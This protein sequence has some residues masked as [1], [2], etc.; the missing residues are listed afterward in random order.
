MFS[1]NLKI[2]IRKRRRAKRIL[3][4]FSILVSCPGYGAFTPSSQTPTWLP[5]ASTCTFWPGSF[6][7]FCSPWKVDLSRLVGQLS[8]IRRWDFVHE[9]PS[10]LDF[11]TGHLRDM[12]LTLASRVY[13]AILNSNSFQ[14]WSEPSSAP[15][16]P[17]VPCILYILLY[18]SGVSIP[19][20]TTCTRNLVSTSA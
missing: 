15:P 18:L 5:N 2:F 20:S 17:T 6:L 8:P 13:P 19:K 14:Q 16:K 4:L 3:Q 9:Y 10:S 7:W 11:Q 12:C 1:Q